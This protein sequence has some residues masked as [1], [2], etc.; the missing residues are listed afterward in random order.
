MT[1]QY[2]NS[3]AKGKQ[4]TFGSHP[5]PPFGSR[6]RLSSLACVSCLCALL[7]TTLHAQEKPAAKVTFDDHAKPVLM[8][9]CSTCHNGERK[10]GDLDVTNFT[11][12]MIGGGSGEVI[13]PGSA[14]DSYL[15]NLVTHEDSPE[16][17]PGGDKIPDPQIE[18]LR[19]WIDG[20]ALENSGSV[21]K[22][23]KP[24]TDYSAVSAGDKRPE[25]EPV[26]SRLPLVPQ[27]VAPRPSTVH[28]L[29]TN[30]WSPYI[31][32]SSPQQVLIY[33]T[34]DL[35][36]RGV[37][38]FPEGQPESI[39]FSRNGSLLL[40]GGGKPGANG[41]VL[42][43]DAV[44]GR[45]VAVVGDE[46]DSVLASDINPSQTLI[47]L[48]GPKKIVRVYGID[49]ELV[50]ELNKHTEWI[51]A[52]QFSPDGKFLVTGDR[53]GG[54]HA[55]EADTGNEVL[56]LGGH[57][58]AITA[59]DWRID[60][61][62]V[63]TASEDGTVRVWDGANGKQIKS[64]T[65]CSAGVTS[66]SFTR[67][68]LVVTG[69]RDRL[70]RV[71]DQNGKQL[72]QYEA[73]P[74]QVT[75]VAYCSETNRVIAGDWTGKINVWEKANPKPIG[76]LNCN[77]PTIESRI[78]AVTRQL[79][80]AEAALKP[81]NEQAATLDSQIAAMKAD[82]DAEV[83]SRTATD[84]ALKSVME[85]LANADQLL[86][87]TV[88]QQEAWKKELTGKEK[89]APQL[90]ASIA[91]AK[92][93]LASL[94]DD[95]E[96]KDTIAK[97]E[98]RKATLAQRIGVLKTQVQ[99][100]ATK[101]ETA[102]AQ[103]ATLSVERDN[104]QK[105]LVSLNASIAAREMEIGKANDQRVKLQAALDKAKADVE[106]PKGALAFWNGELQFAKVLADLESTL[107]TAEADENAKL[108]EVDAAKEKLAAAQ[109]VV[110]QAE[111]KRAESAKQIDSIEQQIETLKAN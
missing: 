49:G 12:L 34:N 67:D 1:T 69:G 5:R 97:L 92:S 94:G 64:W 17:P 72:H 39:R 35:G 40:I 98:A 4:W 111:Q 55:W 23:R 48:G 28:S 52:L 50:Y 15:F 61:K 18:I 107:I 88:G 83:A 46:L 91:S 108:D 21:A 68:G 90:D 14:D 10:E 32:M 104:S 63:V 29:A 26:P 11:N 2:E 85:K 86:K 57:K 24:K 74:D 84:M 96:I 59:I 44:K 42:V 60:G 87:T 25:V 27:L 102:K 76:T 19:K 56:T 7:A 45:R 9:R 47:A 71:W 73:M 31:A 79:Q 110:H 38:P 53:N 100:V 81:L 95:A 13:E 58:K 77:P 62:L 8:Q 6:Q 37:I 43:W 82:N 65:G 36:L 93:A 101:Q 3:T 66:A 109:A 80:S 78:A 16:M 54:V 70:V 30:P 20:G 106:Q 105:Q 41:K 103:I 22:K 89:A 75:S 51:T 33:R 99:Q